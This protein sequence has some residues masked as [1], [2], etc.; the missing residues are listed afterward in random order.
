MNYTHTVRDAWLSK[1][2][3]DIEKGLLAEDMQSVIDFKQF[4][5]QLDTSLSF[6]EIDWPE[7]PYV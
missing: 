4:M 6:D 7:Y 3:S 1:L 2:Q 5:N